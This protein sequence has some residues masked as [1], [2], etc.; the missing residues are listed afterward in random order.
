MLKRPAVLLLSISAVACIGAGH[1]GR[2]TAVDGGASSQATPDAGLTP[3]TP[4]AGPR[5]P[6]DLPPVVADGGLGDN[7]DI[8]VAPGQGTCAAGFQC[9]SLSSAVATHASGGPA[10]LQ[11]CSIA[12]DPSSAID[13]CG[14]FENPCIDGFCYRGCD[15]TASDPCGRCDFVCVPTGQSDSSGVCRPDCTLLS[16]DYCSTQ[17]LYPAQQCNHANGDPWYGS[18]VVEG[19]PGGEGP[20]IRCS[21]D[22]SCP[23]GPACYSL[24]IPRAD[25]GVDCPHEPSYCTTDCSEMPRTSCTRNEDCESGACDPSSRL[26]ESCPHGY[27]CQPNLEGSAHLCE[28]Q[29][30]LDYTPCAVNEQ[31]A[32][33]NV[34][35]EECV[36]EGTQPDPGA[37]AGHCYDPCGDGVTCGAGR[38]CVKLRSHDWYCLVPCTASDTCPASTTCIQIDGATGSF[39]FGGKSGDEYPTPGF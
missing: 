35:P 15:T 7:C 2:W 25:C 33:P 32:I 28:V 26:C 36:M 13:M 38:T 1:D 17:D 24:P 27:A 14:G 10:P 31:C 21:F 16:A 4:D 30:A 3:T 39:C 5:A 19:T 18:C 22:T 9:A 11:M 6:C 34:P 23:D 29:P 20:G 8:A 37:P 12:C